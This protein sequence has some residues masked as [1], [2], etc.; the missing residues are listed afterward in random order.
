MTTLSQATEI[1]HATRWATQKSSSDSLR[2]IGAVAEHLGSSLALPE[3]TSQ[4]V[5]DVI[6]SMQESGLSNASINRR[7]SALSAVLTDAVRRG[8]IERK[9]YIPHLKEP[10][11][12]ERVLSETEERKLL[13]WF[14]SNRPG[15]HE[16]VVFLLNVGCRVGE[17]LD[18][19]WASVYL[20]DGHDLCVRFL[21][22]K[23][24]RNRTVPLNAKASTAIRKMPKDDHLVFNRVAYRT[25]KR[26]WDQM[27]TDLGLSDDSEFV[28][29]CL[30]H[31]FATRLVARGVSLETVSRLLGHSSLQMTMRYAHASQSVLVDAVGKL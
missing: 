29:H 12:R 14:R 30:R 23:N 11:G 28:P 25:F 27:K 9:P 2:N 24:G 1:T 18:L 6:T 4:K 5:Q 22:T 7:L 8:D 20:H 26:A 19:E 15:Y 16:L 13:S 3:I 17:A 31:T 10:E 21:D